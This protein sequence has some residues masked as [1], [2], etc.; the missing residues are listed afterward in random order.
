MIT[1][2]TRRAKAH[3]GAADTDATSGPTRRTDARPSTPAEA[4]P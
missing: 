2:R 3:C 4:Q 1:P